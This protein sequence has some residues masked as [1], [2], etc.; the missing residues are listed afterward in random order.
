MYR[1]RLLFIAF[2]VQNEG[3]F[4]EKFNPNLIIPMDK[5]ET[6]HKFMTKLSYP[7]NMPKRRKWRQTVQNWD[8]QLTRSKREFWCSLKNHLK[9]TLTMFPKSTRNTISVVFSSPKALMKF[10]HIHVHAPPNK[11]PTFIRVLRKGSHSFWFLWWIFYL[12]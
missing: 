4:L 10:L 12:S 5:R 11:S 7:K 6:T 8:Y 2:K 9:H 3:P 1:K